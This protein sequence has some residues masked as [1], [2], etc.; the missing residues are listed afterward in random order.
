MKKY[1]V[2]INK[3]N[4]YS[5]FYYSIK[6]NSKTEAMKVAETKVHHSLVPFIQIRTKTL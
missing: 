1:F 6:A 5:P 4:S 2:Y 3:P